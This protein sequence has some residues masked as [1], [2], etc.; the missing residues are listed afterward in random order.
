METQTEDKIVIDIKSI[1]DYNKYSRGIEKTYEVGTMTYHS[2]TLDLVAIYL[3]GQK[4][5]YTESKTYCEMILYSLMLPTIFIS[6]VCTVIN[7]PL[8][9]ESYG[10]VVVSSLNGINSLLLSVIT[11]LKLDAKAEAHK[12]AAYQFEKLQTSCEFYS[13][14]TSML[15]DENIEESVNTFIDT[16]ETKVREIKETN[17]F[18]IPQSIR[19]RYNDIY[20]Y[21]VFVV[22]KEY[23]T[24]RI[25]NVQ[26]LLDVSNEIEWRKKQNNNEFSEDDI[27]SHY[28]HDFDKSTF[29]FFG[30]GFR[31]HKEEHEDEIYRNINI[32]EPSTTLS[33]LYKIRETCIKDIIK[34]RNLSSDL[35]ISFNRQ[36]E[37]RILETN[38]W[39]HRYI[40][41]TNWLKT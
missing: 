7:V 25:L 36:I 31:K 28:Q 35:N 6:T 21:N 13:G 15:P 5:L 18:V 41:N 11:Y 20:S 16:I 37:N 22:M 17:Q 27:T 29:T 12:A 33:K 2:M 1:T 8:R 32:Y 4:L 39:R 40:F 9:T 10:S 19:Y 26:K 3:K 23:K 24:S 34:Y 30:F 38:K 14:K